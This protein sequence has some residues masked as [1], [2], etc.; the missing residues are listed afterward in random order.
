MRERSMNLEHQLTLN[1][2]AQP[3]NTQS[4]LVLLVDDDAVARMHLRICLQKDGYR[5]AEAKTGTEGLQ[6]Y[7]H[8]HPDIV[9]L[10]ALM[11]EM[12]GFECCA[13]IRKLPGSD[14]IPILIITRL[15]DQKSVDRAFAAGAADF[16][17]KPIHFAVLRQ[18]IRRL[19]QQS[20]LQQQMET[21]N[22]E[23]RQ[24]ASI[25]SLTQIANRRR[26]DEY[27]EQEWRRLL[28]DRQPLSLILC[29]IDCFKAYNDTYGHQKGDRC[30]QQ[31][32]QAIQY[33]AQRPTDLVSRY[34]GEEFAVLLPN[35]DAERAFHTA[36]TAFE[37]VRT[38]AI[39]HIN[40]SVSSTVTLSA[41]I[42]SQEPDEHSTLEEFIANA[43]RAL[44]QAKE[45]GRNRCCL[46]V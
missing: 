20:Q 35:T 11:P 8:L 30:L 7:K 39:L 5:I 18:R 29:D 44:Y 9:L 22:R 27:I 34:G 37:R 4:V 2:S 25:D 10:D 43:D 41:G 46:S 14:R 21:T 3:S 40:S 15:D 32:A 26:F 13:Q 1:S 36:I 28:R 42:S 12:D 33:A 23:L 19:V 24:L 31:V 45:Q 6:L 17:T 38:L 16:I